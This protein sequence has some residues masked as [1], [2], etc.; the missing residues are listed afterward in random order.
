MI[1]INNNN[2][3]KYGL[4]KEVIVF[5]KSMILVFIN[6]KIVS[7][8]KLF[9]NIKIIFNKNIFKNTDNNFSF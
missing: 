2:R 1:H 8:I 3:N 5:K 4:I 9:L 7:L 6:I